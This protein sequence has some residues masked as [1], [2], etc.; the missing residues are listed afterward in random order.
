[1]LEQIF[2]SVIDCDLKILLAIKSALAHS[3]H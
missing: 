2:E 3:F 1:M